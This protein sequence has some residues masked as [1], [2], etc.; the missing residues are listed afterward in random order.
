M[1]WTIF[2]VSF[3]SLVKIIIAVIPN[4][5]IFYEK[6]HLL[7]MLLLLVILNWIKR[8][9]ANDLRAFPIKDNLVFINGSKSLPRNPPNFPILYNCVFDNFILADEPF[10]KAI[11]SFETCV[12]NNYNLA[13]NYFYH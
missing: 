13:A 5:N 10:A 12:L 4:P 7:P 1:N 8:L 11:R 3:I 9:L 6:L 2:V